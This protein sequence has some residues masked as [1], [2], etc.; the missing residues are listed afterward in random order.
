MGGLK[1][2]ATIATFRAGCILQGFL[3]NPMTK[4]F[5]D[6]PNLS[7][8]IVA[9]EPEL[10]S[11]LPKCK[12]MLAQACSETSATMP[13]M[14][15]SADYVQT[16]LATEIPS[17]Q[18]VSLQRDVFGRHGFERLDKQGRFNASWRPT[19]GKSIAGVP[20][21]SAKEEVKIIEGQDKG[22]GAPGY[23]A[24]V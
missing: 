11:G 6:N 12:K 13:C 4:A 1:L 21:S 14:L 18:C 15:A 7:N 5:E 23:M 10:T 24:R 8:L 3:L 17:A 20:D 19:L 2:P 22:R 9:F 16:M